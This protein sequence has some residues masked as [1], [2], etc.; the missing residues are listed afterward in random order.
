MK[1]SMG[2]KVVNELGKKYLVIFNINDELKAYRQF[3]SHEEL[4]AHLP[5]GYAIREFDDTCVKPYASIERTGVFKETE[6]EMVLEL[7]PLSTVKYRRYKFEQSRN[8]N[9]RAQETKTIYRDQRRNNSGGFGVAV[10]FM[11]VTAI[12]VIAIACS[13]AGNVKE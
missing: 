6:Y 5:H 4:Q 2:I 8:A 10:S 3:P 11:M 1:P 9:E 12:T 7:E 13:S